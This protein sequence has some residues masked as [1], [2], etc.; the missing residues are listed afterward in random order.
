MLS[1]FIMQLLL[2]IRQF[3]IIYLCNHSMQMSSYVLHYFKCPHFDWGAK[4]AE[5][6]FCFV[7]INKISLNL[8]ITIL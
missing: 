6:D 5:K 4:K 8:I 2:F 1:A 3:I 7:I